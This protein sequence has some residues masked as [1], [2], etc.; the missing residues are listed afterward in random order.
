MS[1]LENIIVKIYNSL[2]DKGTSLVSRIN[3]I[4]LAIN[5]LE[6]RKYKLETELLEATEICEINIINKKTNYYR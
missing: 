1:N 3:N 2:Q 6:D 5:K 4:L